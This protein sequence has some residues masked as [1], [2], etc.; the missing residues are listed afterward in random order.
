[1]Y[2]S[3]TFIF[4]PSLVRCSFFSLSSFFLVIFLNAYVTVQCPWLP[5]YHPPNNS[6]CERNCLLSVFSYH[7][8]DYFGEKKDTKQERKRVKQCHS[9]WRLPG[10]LAFFLRDVVPHSALTAGHV[11]MGF[12]GEDVGWSIVVDYN[13]IYSSSFQI[14]LC[15]LWGKNIPTYYIVINFVTM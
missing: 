6:N 7:L 14:V 13:D 10:R 1:M 9:S 2:I 11:F 15:L 8:V 12:T 4:F 3:I 5:P